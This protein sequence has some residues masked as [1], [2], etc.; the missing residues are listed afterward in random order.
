MAAVSPFRG[1]RYSPALVPDLSRVVAPPYDI[2]GPS[3]QQALHERS[4]YNAVRLELGLPKP[5]DDGGDNVYQRAAEALRTWQAQGVLVRDAQ[6]ALYLAEEE[7]PLAGKPKTRLVVYAAVTLEPWERGVVLPHEETT[8]G[9]KQDR[10][11]LLRACTMNISPVMGLYE[12]RGGLHAFLTHHVQTEP[13]AAGPFTV[14]GVTYRTWVVHDPLL[15]GLVQ[16]ALRDERLY[17]A[18]GHHRYETALAYE[19]EAGAPLPGAK[20][21]L[22]GLVSLGDPGLEVQAFHRTLAGLT[23]D[24]AASLRRRLR[25]TCELEPFPTSGTLRETAERLLAA[26]KAQ[27]E[28]PCSFGL[29]DESGRSAALLRLKP[30]A[31]LP[32]APVTEFRACEPWVLHRA[33]LDPVL[34]RDALRYLAFQHGLDEV[35]DALAGGQ[36]QMAFLVR[37]IPLG[38]FRRIVAKG[39]RLPPKTTY[40]YPKLPTG[41]VLRSLEE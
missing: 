7:F 2:I 37:A 3:L 10:L 20:Q 26:L 31:V 38:L 36:A 30:D 14:E 23:N 33:M 11:S 41:L 19:G 32:E 6:P 5:G 17:V 22:M 9:P 13:P 27:G 15:N 4:P 1:W 24:Q 21:V 28:T 18:D 12:E 34:G 29:L 16:Q 39:Q 8:P 40:F 25:E 35:T